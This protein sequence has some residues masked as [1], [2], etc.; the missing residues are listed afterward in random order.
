M[1][2]NGPRPAATLSERKKER[3]KE[4]NSERND[5]NNK[6]LVMRPRSL[7]EEKHLANFP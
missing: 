3:K 7:F 5:D 2:R 6:I 4:R 1:G